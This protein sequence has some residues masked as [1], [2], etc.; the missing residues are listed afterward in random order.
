MLIP[1]GYPPKA[2]KLEESNEENGPQRRAPEDIARLF[3]ETLP[4]FGMNK[5]ERAEVARRPRA[6]GPI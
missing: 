4:R 2:S 1:W 6:F 5:K 3:S